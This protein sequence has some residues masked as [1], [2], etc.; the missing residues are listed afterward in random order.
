ML[1]K[2]LLKTAKKRSGQNPY[3][4]KFV[5]AGKGNN[6]NSN[7]ARGT[8]SPEKEK[9]AGKWV[10][11]PIHGGSDEEGEEEEEDDGLGMPKW[12]VLVHKGADG[13]FYGVLEP[14][15]PSEF[16]TGW[17]L[18]D[19]LHSGY[20]LLKTAINTIRGNPSL[21][22][23]HLVKIAY[24]EYGTSDRFGLREVRLNWDRDFSNKMELNKM[25]RR[26]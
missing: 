20:L 15:R 26:K 24:R 3:V 9:N 25:N 6:P 5:V 2:H 8:K 16:R 14:I 17:T 11:I 21:E 22:L 18:V 13:Q 7:T 1:K 23:D 10:Q 19:D 12:T 4:V